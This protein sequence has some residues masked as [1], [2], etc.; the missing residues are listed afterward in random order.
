MVRREAVEMLRGH[1]AESDHAFP[2]KFFRARLEFLLDF[3]ARIAS[4]HGLHDHGV[5]R[6]AAARNRE[7][8]GM[9]LDLGE[10]NFRIIAA[11]VIEG[12][13]RNLK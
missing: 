10:D 2:Q 11:G 3:R 4:G 9:L 7:L 6:P 1:F 13:R 5:Q 12:V 8:A